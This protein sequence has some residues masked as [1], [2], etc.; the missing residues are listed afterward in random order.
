MS[1][2]DLLTYLRGKDD[3]Q[4]STVGGNKSDKKSLKSIK[5]N[6]TEVE[7]W[8]IFRQVLCG[9]KYLHYQNIVHGDIKPQNLL[10]NEDDIVKIADF[11]ISKMIHGGN[12]KL[13][14]ASGDDIF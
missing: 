6:L 2:G 4:D 12:E 3:S 10:V 14:D 7:L 11:G 5:F 9:I 1:K 8:N 13:K